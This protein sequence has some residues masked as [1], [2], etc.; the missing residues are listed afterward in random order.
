VVWIADLL[1]NE[2]ADQI[3]QMM[4]QGMAVMKSTLDALV[5]KSEQVAAPQ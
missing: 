3:G 2:A 1:P 4:E 5:G